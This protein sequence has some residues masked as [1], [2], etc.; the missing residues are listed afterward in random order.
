MKGSLATG[1]DV[2][3]SLEVLKQK[4]ERI[5]R[6]I[7]ESSG[8]T[9]MREAIGNVAEQLNTLAGDQGY[10]FSQLMQMGVE[11]GLDKSESIKDIR[12]KTDSVQ[13]ATEIM[14]M[15]MENKLGGIDE[16]VVHVIYE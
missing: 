13:G 2:G 12:K 8:N 14:Q 4:V 11:K 16:P 10:D 5:P 3:K 15:I 7:A 1:G 6:A 9:Q